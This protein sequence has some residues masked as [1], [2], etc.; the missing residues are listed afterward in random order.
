MNAAKADGDR[1]AQT[2]IIVRNALYKGYRTL[3][4]VHATHVEPDGSQSEEEK[5]DLLI[6]GRV[7]GII[8]HDPTTDLL[9]LIR[10][11]RLAAQLATGK[12]DLVELVAGGIEDGEEADTS[13]RR[14][15]EE[16]TGLQA[17]RVTHLFDVM[18]TPGICTELAHF[19]YAEVDASTLPDRAGEDE[20][21]ATFP[22]AIPTDEAI[23]LIDSGTCANGFLNLGL[24]WF[25]RARADGRMP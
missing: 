23:S 8:A 6:A 2:D 13:V 18:P 22:F 25:A 11:Y 4:Q 1:P 24:H 19:F 10:Q 17:R 12:G 20:Q 15:L 7:V 16:E 3:E 21:E 5:R 14:E 9:V